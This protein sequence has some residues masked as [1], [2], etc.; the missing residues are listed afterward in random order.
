MIPRLVSFKTHDNETLAADTPSGSVFPKVH[1]R[2]NL[3]VSFFDWAKTTYFGTYVG[4]YIHAIDLAFAAIVGWMTK[5]WMVNPFNKEQ[6]TLRKMEL[7]Q[8][9]VKNNHLE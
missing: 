4:D 3:A 7:V 9:Y 6:N 2:K 8:Q 1:P 5:K